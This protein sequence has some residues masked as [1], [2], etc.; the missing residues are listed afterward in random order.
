[1]GLINCN[2]LL[3][4]GVHQFDDDHSQLV[5]I[6]NQLHHAFKTGDKQQ[7]VNLALEQLAEFTSYH[8]QA[9]ESILEQHNYPHLDEHRQ[10][11][12]QIL[13]RFNELQI[14]YHANPATM[15]QNLMQFLLD[16]LISH[17]KTVDQKYG[18]FLNSKGI[19]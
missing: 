4:V 11:H 1:M 17:T 9:E 2:K 7:S 8:F 15:Q 19:Y 5:A 3:T 12:Q 13:N 16:W 6:I 14:E 10:A 18:P